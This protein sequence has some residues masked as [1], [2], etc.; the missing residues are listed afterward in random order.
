MYYKKKLSKNNKFM[1]TNNF[2][3]GI[4]HKKVPDRRLPTLSALSA[5]RDLENKMNLL[6][7]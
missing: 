2:D 7:G 3:G 1:L 5:K 6:G 4:L